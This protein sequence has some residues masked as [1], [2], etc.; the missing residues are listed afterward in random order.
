M[1]KQQGSAEAQDE[2][3][4]NK[5]PK[6]RKGRFEVWNTSKKRGSSRWRTYET[7]EVA[8]KAMD[9]FRVKYSFY[10]WEIRVRD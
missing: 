3:R 4:N 8:E 9:G 6:R 2:G 5:V 1:S 7:R 10:E